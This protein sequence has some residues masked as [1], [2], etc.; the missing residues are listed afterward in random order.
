MGP[1]VEQ[2]GLWSLFDQVAG[3]I[4]GR[5]ARVE[6]R[7][8]ARLFL[9][10]LLSGVERKN[11]WNLAEQA[12]LGDPQPMQRLLREAVWDADAVRDD[13]RDLVVEHLGTPGAVLVVDETGFLKKG[14]HS[15]GVQRQYTGTAGRIENAQVAVFL[16][17]ACPAGRALIDRRVYLPASWTEHPERCAAAGTPEQ[18]GFATKPRLALEMIEQARAAGVPADH[19]AADEVYGN[20]PAFR[21]GIK[22]LG[23]G[24]VLAVACDHRVTVQGRIRRRV[25]RIAADLPRSAWQ[26]YSAGAGSKGP[27]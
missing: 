20:D 26:R 17:Y 11:C 27:R 9:L 5:F 25:D 19:V 22:A 3:R 4:A 7:R 24:Y 14:G 1:S 2:A 12:G 23:L 10:G 6:P 18:T 8:T 21:A 16:A 13:V 15:I